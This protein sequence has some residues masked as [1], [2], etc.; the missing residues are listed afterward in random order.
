MR[1][2]LDAMPELYRDPKVKRFSDECRNDMTKIFVDTF[3]K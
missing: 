3:L 1:E 2:H